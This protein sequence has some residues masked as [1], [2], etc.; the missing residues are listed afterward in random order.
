VSWRGE[1]GSPLITGIETLLGTLLITLLIDTLLGS[2][3]EAFE[4]V[5]EQMGEGGVSPEGVFVAEFVY[6]VSKLFAPG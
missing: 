3:G 2:E 1:R 4:R 5:E 6:D